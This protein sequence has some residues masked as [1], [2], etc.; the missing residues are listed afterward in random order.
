S[1]LDEGIKREMPFKQ[2]I[3]RPHRDL[4][5]LGQIE[6]ASEYMS[7]EALRVRKGVCYFSAE[8]QIKNTF[9]YV[10]SYEYPEILV[11]RLD[12]KSESSADCVMFLIIK[13]DQEIEE[14]KEDL[15]N[16][17]DYK[18]IYRD[19][20]VVLWRLR[21]RDGYDF[22]ARGEEIFQSQKKKAKV[23]LWSEVFAD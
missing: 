15:A 7:E 9:R 14:I 10:M 20:A 8:Y 2:P 5:T 4:V 17:F 3:L 6:R 12:S 11:K 21:I 19:G 16:R 22:P 18:K 23:Y 1:S 13:S